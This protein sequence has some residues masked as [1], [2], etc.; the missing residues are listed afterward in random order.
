MLRPLFNTVRDADVDVERLLLLRHQL[1]FGASVE[2]VEGQSPWAAPLLQAAQRAN[3]PATLLIVVLPL[4]VAWLTLQH[5]DEAAGR[6]EELELKGLQ[7]EQQQR[8]VE[9]QQLKK[10]GA[11]PESTGALSEEAMRRIAEEVA[12][13]IADEQQR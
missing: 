9:R 5:G 6:S 3:A 8:D 1:L 13:R 7:L 4:V 2:E 12:R 11:R 10:M